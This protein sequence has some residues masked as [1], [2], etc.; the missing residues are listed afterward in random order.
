MELN[1]ITF[2]DL[3]K[4]ATV[5]WWKSLDSVPATMRQSGIV[6]EISIPEMSGNTREFS[7]IDLEEY[8]SRKGQ[9][10][11]AERA[12]VQQG[13]SA[14][15]TAYR[16]AKDIG[17][18]Y[19][20]RTQG[21]YPEIKAELTNLGPLAVNRNDLDLSHRIG[22]CTATT[23]TDKDGESVAIDCGDDLQLAYSAHLL[24]GSTTTFRNRLANNP[25]LSKGAIEG[26]ERL[27]VE[28]TY[29]Q[30]GE[31]KVMPFDILW[32]TDDPNTRNTA[33]EYLKSKSAPD[34]A[35]SDVINVYQGSYRHVVLP[36]VATTA[37][38]ARDTAKRYYWGL[39]S[40]KHSTFYMGMWEEAHLKVPKSLNA[41]EEFATDDWNFG[42]RM[43]YGIV[44]PS[45][46]WFKM[47]SGDGSA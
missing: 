8:A 1:T 34:A 6:K 11:Q 40:S 43:G 35:H 27:I 46:T 31:K 45:A 25:R 30:F 36:R 2:S 37:A 10:D 21:K 22:F 32:T 19:E 28:E 13:Y 9:S 3:V 14:T 7:E 24:K 4:L 20:W 42:V 16:V 15:M 38:G 17:V 39:I 29:N 33:Q 41:G 5:I 18:S 44:I 12:S 26:M 47:S 23:Y